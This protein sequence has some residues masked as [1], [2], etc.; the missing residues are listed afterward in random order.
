MPTALRV[1][2]CWQVGLKHVKRDRSKTDKTVR[3]ATHY[4]WPRHISRQEFP[5]QASACAASPQD[6]ALQRIPA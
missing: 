2:P 6:Q 1:Q 3:R 4:R 5:G